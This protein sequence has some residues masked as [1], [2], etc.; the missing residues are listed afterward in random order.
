MEKF[1]EALEDVELDEEADLEEIF[2]ALSKFDSVAFDMK[3]MSVMR[4]P[5]T[6][7]A[8]PRQLGDWITITVDAGKKRISCDCEQCNRYGICTW[9]DTMMVIQFDTPV[10]AHCKMPDKG[11]GWKAKVLRARKVMRDV[12]INC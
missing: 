5:K 12:N 4:E 10:A 6:R 8:E 11:F 7:I 2:G 9:V 1:N 3:E